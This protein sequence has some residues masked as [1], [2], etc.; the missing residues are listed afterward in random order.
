MQCAE[1]AQILFRGQQ[2]LDPRSMADPQQVTRQ[3]RALFV[4]RLTVEQNLTVGRLHEARK[5]A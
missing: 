5:Q 4:K 1:P 2:V 3:L